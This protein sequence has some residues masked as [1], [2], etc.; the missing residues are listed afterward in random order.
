MCPATLAHT[1][2]PHGSNNGN[3]S[4][5]WLQHVRCSVDAAACSSYA[6]CNRGPL[7]AP[8]R[9][10]ASARAPY[11]WI[12]PNSKGKCEG[13]PPSDHVKQRHARHV[14]HF[15]DVARHKGITMLQRRGCRQSD[16]GYW[17]AGSG[18]GA[19]EPRQVRNCVCVCV[20]ACVC[21]CVCVYMSAHVCV[22]CSTRVY[23]HTRS[24]VLVCIY[25]Y[26]RFH[27]PKAEIDTTRFHRAAV[28]VPSTPD[29]LR[30]HLHPTTKHTQASTSTAELARQGR[31][32]QH[33]PGPTHSR[34]SAHSRA[35]ARQGGKQQS[36]H[37]RAGTVNTP[38]GS[39]TH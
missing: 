2:A 31:H 6:L 14:Q 26:V 12:M 3:Q 37:A 8:A 34:A 19:I 5:S 17:S 15:G 21:M 7:S 11:L 39:C 38:Q 18:T 29:K 33:T 30:A 1:T 16:W 25:V 20:C 27:R 24:C 13:S 9:G 28:L 36:R 10:S 35:R 32:S 4:R 23:M 22:C